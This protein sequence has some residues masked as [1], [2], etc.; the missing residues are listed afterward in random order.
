MHS[1]DLD[2]SVIG[3]GDWNAQVSVLVHSSS[4]APVS[5]VFVA[6]SY[7]GG[8]SGQTSCVTGADGRCSALAGQA[9]ASATSVTFTVN[10]MTKSGSTYVPSSNHD[11]DGD[12]NGTTIVITKPVTGTPPPTGTPTPTPTATPTPTSPPAPGPM[13]SGDLDGFAL[14][15]GDWNAKVDVYV[16]DANHLPVSG[17]LVAFTYSGGSNGQTS[18]VT[19]AA[20]ACNVL[21]SQAP[22]SATSVTFTI[23]NMTRS[24]FSYA[25]GSNHDTDGDSTGTTI[26]VIKP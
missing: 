1:G 4:H 25:P 16:H 17:A 9:P 19:N 14:G 7:S 6:L 20:G 10:N 13:H 2:G 26:V 18:C 21:A 5:G 12:S 8:A 11:P 15:T 3:T 22:A 24:G 23:T